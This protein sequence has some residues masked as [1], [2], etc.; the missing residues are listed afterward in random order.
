[1]E[2]NLEKDLYMS[3]KTTWWSLPAT[4][5][6]R[7]TTFIFRAAMLIAPLM[8]GLGVNYYADMV[9]PLGIAVFFGILST[10]TCYIALSRTTKSERKEVNDLLTDTDY[11]KPSVK[12]TIPTE[13]KD[14]YMELSFFP[15][16]KEWM[17]SGHLDP[18]EF[19]TEIQTIDILAD[20]YHIQELI[21]HVKHVYE[22]YEHSPTLKRHAVKI[23]SSPL[24]N[25]FP[26]TLVRIPPEEVADEND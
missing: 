4:R 9:F 22:S 7:S 21:P 16:S 19:I 14:H 26:V 12:M 3:L 8:V 15:T 11:M 24:A 17:A 20:S 1:M 18:V 2:S 5:A 10:V 6:K 25:T 13:H 23:L